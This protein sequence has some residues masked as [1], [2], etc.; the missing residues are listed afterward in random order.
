MPYYAKQKNSSLYY[1]ITDPTEIDRRLR[2]GQKEVPDQYDTHFNDYYMGEYTVQRYTDEEY[3]QLKYEIGLFNLEERCILVKEFAE[4][5]QAAIS[6][7]RAGAGTKYTDL[8]NTLTCNIE[9]LE[10]LVQLN[11]HLLHTYKT[12]ASRWWS[13]PGFFLPGDSLLLAIKSFYEDVLCIKL[14]TKVTNGDIPKSATYAQGDVYLQIIDAGTYELTI[15]P[16]P[17]KSFRH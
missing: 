12:I 2:I 17:P 14:D 13:R 10:C 7:T 5:K 15:A 9:A 3:R 16:M 11:Q 6:Y 4:I 8:F 1:L